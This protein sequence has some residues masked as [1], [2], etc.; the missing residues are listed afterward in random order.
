[1]D[2]QGDWKL[3]LERAVAFLAEAQAREHPV[4]LAGTAFS[5]V[6]LLDHLEAHRVRLQLPPGSR[7]LE[8]A[9]IKGAPAV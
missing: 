1:V 8:T 4:L 6:H 3:D 9:A 2:E 5:F 7:A